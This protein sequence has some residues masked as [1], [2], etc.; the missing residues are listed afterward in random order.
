MVT[1]EIVGEG[2]FLA[3]MTGPGRGFVQT[4]PFSRLADRIMSAVHG[5]KEEVRRGDA[6]GAI[7]GI[8]S[9]DD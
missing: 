1:H 4:L 6:L 9:G 2:L 5:N 8:I 3:K 7:D